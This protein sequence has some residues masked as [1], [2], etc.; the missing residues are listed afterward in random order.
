[1]ATT[2]AEFSSKEE[3]D[4]ENLWSAILSDVHTSGDSKLPTGKALV[5]L[6]NIDCGKTTLVAKLEGVEDPRKGA[7]L[8]YHVVNVQDEYGETTKLGTWLL[9]G[10][11][12]HTNLLKYVLKENDFADT[13]IILTASMA[14]PWSLMDSLE[15][16]AT[17][18]QDHIDKL[19]LDRNVLQEH[20]NKVVRHFQEYV[21]P[22]TQSPDG[23]RRSG[24]L[25]PTA[26]ED[27]EFGDS[28][29]TRNVG[30]PIVVVITKCDLMNEL[31]RENDF[32]DEQF[33]FIQQAV[34][35]FCLSFGAAL[36][37]T[38]VKDDK[39][40]DLL[41]KYLVHRLYGFHFNTP[42]YVVERDSI[43]I[44]SGWD[45]EK[46]IS[47][48]YENFNKVK[49][50]DRY[51]DVIPK[52]FPRRSVQKDADL[53]AEDDQAFLVK[54][55]A[56]LNTS[57]PSSSAKPVDN[58]TKSPVGIRGPA[59]P[60]PG[61]PGATIKDVSGPGSET[62]LA[63]FFNSLL[64]KKAPSSPGNGG[65]SDKEGSKAGESEKLKERSPKPV[66]VTSSPK[67]GGR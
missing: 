10:D 59:R 65:K 40:C 16:W 33:D 22:L 67:T 63:N 45:N 49:S 61:Q 50:D 60:S 56:Q 8:E 29:L 38:S 20:K 52:P 32:R 25:S 15:N 62:V 2:N 18:L 37:Y 31:V 3:H 13:L 58:A 44:P 9:D 19:R 30:L 53:Q 39:N 42:A 46:K 24:I 26:D 35:K 51:S 5:I 47:I 1:M 28:L 17:I 43:F 64:S 57:V 41:Y 7:G 55:Q 48:L 23:G 66:S 36:F 14:Q 12:Y 4:D 27:F 11:T 34:R 6:G 21:E 54:L